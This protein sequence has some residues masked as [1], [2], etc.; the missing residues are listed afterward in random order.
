MRKKISFIY[1]DRA[2]A[3][4][5]RCE[6]VLNENRLSAVPDANGNVLWIKANALLYRSRYKVDM[7]EENNTY[8]YTLTFM[9]DIVNSA[10]IW[11]LG[12]MH[13][14]LFVWC[15]YKWMLA[16]ALPALF[17]YSTLMLCTLVFYGTL[18]RK[19]T[20]AN[21]MAHIDRCSHPELQESSK[22]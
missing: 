15:M 10:V 4:L 21:V 18:T 2:C 7:L 19:L 1:N 3:D 5:F 12:L 8:K 11:L 17:I 14:G 20:R 6:E 9:N 22:E 16:E 13:S